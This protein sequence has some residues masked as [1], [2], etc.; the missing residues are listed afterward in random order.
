MNKSHDY[1]G[2]AALLTAMATRTNNP[3]E[4]AELLGYADAA[5]ML[6][7]PRINRGAVVARA[8]RL[9]AYGILLAK[10]GYALIGHRLRATAVALNNAE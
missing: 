10:C 4:A 1:I 5:R 9:E 2:L 7:N 6:S 8:S 3:S